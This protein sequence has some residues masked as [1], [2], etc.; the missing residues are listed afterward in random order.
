MKFNVVVGNPPYNDDIYIPFVEM[1]HNISKDC[2]NFITPARWQAKGGDIN[3]KFR[4]EIVPYMNKIVYYPDAGDVFDI[5]LSGGISYYI[6]DK[7]VHEK[8]Q[9]RTICTV[10][11]PFN[12]NGIETFKFNGVLH[13]HKVRGIIKKLD[14]YKQL[15]CENRP[16]DGK[17]NVAYTSLYADPNLCNKQGTAYVIERPYIQTTLDKRCASTTFI[18]TFETEQEATSLI[19]YLNTKF[20]RFMFLIGKC[21]QNN[22]YKYAWRYIP[23]PVDY[24]HIFTDDELYKKYSLNGDEIDMIEKII[25]ARQ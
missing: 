5:A 25:K 7:K 13:N 20:I 21:T 23:D 10:Q 22:H 12:T 2:C 24:D 14:E 1:G 4:D 11:K 8:Q 3:D 9:L 17:Y 15:Y 19:S 16:V 6:I 18:K